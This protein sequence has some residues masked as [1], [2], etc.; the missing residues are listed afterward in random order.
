MLPVMTSSLASQ[1][2]QK[3]NQCGSGLAREGGVSANTDVACDDV[4]AGKP[5]PTKTESM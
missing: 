1:L 5:A 3:P 4:F 2:L